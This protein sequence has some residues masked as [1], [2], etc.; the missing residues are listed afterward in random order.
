MSGAF[1][2]EKF[3]HYLETLQKDYSHLSELL[4]KKREAILL[5]DLEAI[6]AIMKDEQA[7]V[8]LSR[9]FNHNIEAFREELGLSGSTLT[10]TID[11]MPAEWQPEFRSLLEPLKQIIDEV[12]R[13]NEECQELTEKKLAQIGKN[14]TRLGATSMK[15][16]AQ[17]AAPAKP[18]ARGSS[19]NKSI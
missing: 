2:A 14:L 11:S 16:Y 7:F 17:S 19:F 18:Q 4:E 10:E 9:G 12:R 1:P 6:N 8:L 3:L 5:Y 13:R 15:P